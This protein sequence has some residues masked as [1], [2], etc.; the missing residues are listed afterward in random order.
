MHTT[1]CFVLGCQS[2]KESRNR[3]LQPPHRR[4]H[5]QMD[6]GHE[7]S[8]G[9]ATPAS[10]ISAQSRSYVGHLLSRKSM[11]GG[12]NAI[13]AANRIASSALRPSQY[14]SAHAG[15]AMRSS[16]AEEARKQQ[17]IGSPALLFDQQLHLFCK[18]K[19]D[20]RLCLAVLP[21]R[22]LHP[23]LS[24]IKCGIRERAI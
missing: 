8:A 17:Q 5:G 12:G 14:S 13:A 11:P 15:P 22:F 20:R 9:V 16:P 18:F 6:R 21:R 7:A 1:Q 3:K 23:C 24:R 4:G 10:T 19:T 2:A